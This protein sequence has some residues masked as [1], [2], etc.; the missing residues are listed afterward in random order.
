MAHARIAS[1]SLGLTVEC[2]GSVQLQEQVSPTPET[3]EEAEGTAAHVVAVAHAAGQIWPVGYK[4]S[5]SGREWSVTDDMFD[6]AQMFTKAMG[7][8]HGNLRLEDGVSITEVHPTECFGTPDGWRYFSEGLG[9]GKV[10]VLRV[11]DYKYGHRYVEEFENH[12]LVSY[13][14][15]VMQR[16][17]LTDDNLILELIIVQPRCFAAEPVRVWRVPAIETRALVNIESTAAELALG[18]NPPTRT[19]NHC[20]DCKARHACKTLRYSAA[21]IVTFAGTAEAAVL[22]PTAMGQELRML[23][24]AAKQLEARRTGVAAQVEAFLRAGKSVP[25]W[26]LEPMRSNRQWNEG[27]TPEQIAD[28]GDALG[29]NLRKPAAVITPTQAIDAGIDEDI[30]MEYAHRPKPRLGLK[31]DKSAKIRKAFSTIRS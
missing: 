5:S 4:F 7:G 2:H 16:L 19:G 14:R 15:G 10:P 3:E 22:D 8:Y 17:N 13:A 29:I 31:P 24:D 21:A 20:M 27:L 11:G 23:D 6:G 26:G 25:M 28:T 9:P 30:V 18:P 12:Q 1:S